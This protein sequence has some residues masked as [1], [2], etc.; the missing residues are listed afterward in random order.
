MVF[1]TDLDGSTTGG[2]PGSLLQEPEYWGS[3]GCNTEFLGTQSM[4]NVA[5]ARMHMPIELHSRTGQSNDKDLS[6]TLD[7][8]VFGRDIDGSSMMELPKSK[9]DFALI[10]QGRQVKKRPEDNPCYPGQKR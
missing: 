3:K 10:A 8:L 7:T 2:G 5:S 9:A 4:L 6:S 1:G